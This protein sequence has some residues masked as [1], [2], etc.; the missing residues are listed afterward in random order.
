MDRVGSVP[1][2]RGPLTEGACSRDDHVGGVVLAD[3]ASDEIRQ[4][5]QTPTGVWEA[6]RQSSPGGAW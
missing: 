1:E 6:G 4:I 3:K 2:R 5:G